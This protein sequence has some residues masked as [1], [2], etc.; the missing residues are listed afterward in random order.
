MLFVNSIT[1]LIKI[2]VSIDWLF[3]RY[4][5]VFCADSS[6]FVIIVVLPLVNLHNTAPVYILDLSASLMCQSIKLDA[7]GVWLR[8][9][10]QYGTNKCWRGEA[11]IISSFWEHINS[12]S[13]ALKVNNYLLRFRW[14]RL[15]CNWKE[16]SKLYIK[17]LLFY[18]IKFSL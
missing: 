3:S 7:Y 8:E 17:R 4:R 11:I 9:L 13:V 6:M 10:H 5:L 2:L 14:H 12:V 1:I 15:K 18:A 16:R